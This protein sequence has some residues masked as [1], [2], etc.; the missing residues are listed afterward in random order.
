MI[1]WDSSSPFSPELCYS[2]CTTT[3]MIN[4]YLPVELVSDGQFIR[5]YSF[6]RLQSKCNSNCILCSETTWMHGQ[7]YYIL[8]NWIV[9]VCFFCSFLFGGFINISMSNISAT[10]GMAVKWLVLLRHRKK[11]LGANLL[12]FSSRRLHVLPGL[13]WVPTGALGSSQRQIRA[14]ST[15]ER[16]KIF[17]FFAA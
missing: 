11:V 12:V 14:T 1:S 2:L 3:S 5:C 17:F 10:C 8:Q 6:L 16:D 7:C 15:G 9:F 13:L 4:E